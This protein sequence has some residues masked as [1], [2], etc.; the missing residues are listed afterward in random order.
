MHEGC[1]ARLESFDEALSVNSCPRNQVVNVFVSSALDRTLKST[2]LLTNFHHH[3]EQG[4]QR[5]QKMKVPSAKIQSEQK[6][7]PLNVEWARM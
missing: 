6:C 1:H 2:Y 7:S 3:Y 4:L 5:V